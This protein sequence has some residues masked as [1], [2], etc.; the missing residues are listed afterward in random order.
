[1]APVLH[2][3]VREGSPSSRLALEAGQ[4]LLEAGYHQQVPV[5]SGFLNLFVLMEGE[6]R[7]LRLTDDGIEVRGLGRQLSV[8]EAARMVEDEPRLWSANALL[9]PIAQDAML[10]TA[11]YVGGPAEVAYHAQIGS[12]Y[13]HFGV[14]RPAL[15]FRPSVT[16]VEPA[17]TR[18]LEAEGLSLPDLAE[19]PEAIVARWAREAYPDVEAA[20]NRTLESIER[21]MGEVEDTLGALDPTLR[22]A[23]ASARGRALHQVKGLHEKAMRALKKRDMSRVA[24][25]RRTRDALFPGGSFQERGLGHL[26]A[27]AR[28]GLA[29]VGELQQI[30]DPFARGHQVVR[31]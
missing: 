25:L 28:H 10:P 18:A 5:R 3:E 2:R 13:E 29:L 21:E 12:A 26:G 22:A 30:V 24:R 8:E 1:M 27:L 6:R 19:D 7:A 4:A 11:A 17:Q 23:T 20:F 14:P 31:L 9:R 16:L 15:V